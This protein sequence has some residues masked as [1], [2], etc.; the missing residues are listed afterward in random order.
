MLYEAKTSNVKYDSASGK[1]FSI[2]VIWCLTDQ[3]RTFQL[4]I[5]GNARPSIY[6]FGLEKKNEG[7]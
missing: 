3:L 2:N 4:Y 5:S 7:N 1:I 6:I